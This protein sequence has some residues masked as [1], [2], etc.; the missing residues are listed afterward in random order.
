MPT[1]MEPIKNEEVAVNTNYNRKYQIFIDINELL[2]MGE[3]QS[4][5]EIVNKIRE[6]I[7]TTH[8]ITSAA[9]IKEHCVIFA[10]V[11][12]SSRC[13]WKLDD[14]FKAVTN[15]ITDALYI[16]MRYQDVL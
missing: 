15:E 2:D 13:E 7:V 16:T 12:K 3:T 1:M 8:C 10:V 5:E 9:T 14:I 6:K 11:R 4:V